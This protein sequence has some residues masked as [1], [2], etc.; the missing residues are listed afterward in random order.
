MVGVNK[1]WWEEVKRIERRGLRRQLARYRQMTPGER[2]AIAA[3]VTNAGMRLLADAIRQQQ[4]DI[5]EEAIR[6]EIRRRLL[7]REL[8]AAVEQHLI[9]QRQS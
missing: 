8:F 3:D 5:D 6:R 7:P 4:P 9:Q 1:G 2:L